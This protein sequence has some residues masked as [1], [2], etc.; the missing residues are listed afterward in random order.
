MVV[1]AIDLWLYVSMRGWTYNVKDHGAAA[2]WP[3]VLAFGAVCFPLAASAFANAVFDLW[4][5]RASMRWRATAGRVTDSTIE[6]P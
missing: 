5:A 2:F 1:L 4:S 3:I 6:I